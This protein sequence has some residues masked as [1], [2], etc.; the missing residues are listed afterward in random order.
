MYGR[1]ASVDM[2]GVLSKSARAPQYNGNCAQRKLSHV[3][4]AQI[5]HFM[6]VCVQRHIQCMKKG[7]CRRGTAQNPVLLRRRLNTSVP[8][9]EDDLVVDFDAV[10]TAPAHPETAPEEPDRVKIVRRWPHH[11][12]WSGLITTIREVS[13][14]DSSVPIRARDIS[15]IQLAW[16]RYYD[17][18]VQLCSPAFW[19]FFLPMHTLSRKAVDT[20]LRSASNTFLDG[21]TQSFPQSTRTLF[22]R[23]SKVEPFWPLV[24]HSVQ[25]NLSKFD[26][27]EKKQ[28]LTF[29]FVDPL[30]AWVSAA[31]KQPPLEMQWI[32]Q[33][34]T[35]NG[36]QCYGG[37]LQ[38]GEAFAEAYRTCPAGTYPMCISLHWDGSQA[39]GLH[40]TPISIGVANTN[41]MSAETQYCI[42]YIPVLSDLGDHFESQATEIKFY[43]RNKSIGAILQALEVA[44]HSGVRCRL[45]SASSPGDEEEMILMPRLFSMNL[46]QPEAQLYFGLQN[47]T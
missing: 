14:S 23:I 4:S 38:F 7:K 6:F 46:D 33:V 12:L 1:R 9:I 24:M 32:P 43:I 27:P 36:Q 11:V 47:R 10:V 42:G 8:I 29:E 15:R 39:H 37:G 26:L 16:R 45:P 35:F 21:S 19:K 2:S 44:S 25:I 20:A 28:R 22:S 31:Y 5:L 34:Q 13:Q 18:V 41:S 30:W 17:K 40:A 3:I